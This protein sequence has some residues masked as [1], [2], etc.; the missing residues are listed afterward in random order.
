MRLLLEQGLLDPTLSSVSAAKDWCCHRDLGSDHRG[1]LDFPNA[2]R[3]P[4]GPGS[5]RTASVTAV[6]AAISR[7]LTTRFQITIRPIQMQI[8]PLRRGNFSTVSKND[9]V[10]TGLLY[11]RDPAVFYVTL[12]K[13]EREILLQ[14]L[15]HLQRLLISY[16]RDPAAFAQPGPLTAS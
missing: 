6:D 4:S 11:K 12:P 3:S 10:T 9:W 15:S 1:K 2:G 5:T 16:F 13:Q 7:F 14:S 8:N